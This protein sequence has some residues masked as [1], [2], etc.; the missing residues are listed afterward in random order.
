MIDLRKRYDFELREK[1]YFIIPKTKCKK[2]YDIKRYF[3]Y[4]YS[5]DIDICENYVIVLRPS[6]NHT[7]TLFIDRYFNIKY[8]EGYI[9]FKSYKEYTIEKLYNILFPKMTYEKYLQLML[10]K[11]NND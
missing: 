3:Q 11:Y 4:N 8:F 6:N 2:F 1:Y 10:E 7:S 9:D 5:Y